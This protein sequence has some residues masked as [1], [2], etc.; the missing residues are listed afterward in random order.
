MGLLWQQWRAALATLFAL[1]VLVL[2][3][4]FASARG[5]LDQSVTA[6]DNP[7]YIVDA[8]NGSNYAEAQ[9]FTAGAARPSDPAASSSGVR[10]VTRAVAANHPRR[11]AAE[12]VHRTT[13]RHTDGCES[14][15]PSGTVCARRSFGKRCNPDRSSW[16]RGWNGLLPTDP[17][18]LERI[19][20]DAR[21][22]FAID[23]D[24]RR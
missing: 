8:S 18:R 23:R 15:E 22:P 11:A 21:N 14:R 1:D 10:T 2:G 19:A 17:G 5:T 7:A 16:L 12:A 20:R 24:F 13:T 9:T 4:E 3:P 6:V